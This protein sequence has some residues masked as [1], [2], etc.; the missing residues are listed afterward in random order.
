VA[1]SATTRPKVTEAMPG[2][3]GVDLYLTVD[4]AANT[5]EPSYRIISSGGVG[6]PIKDVGGPTSIPSSWFGGTTGFGVGIIS[7]SS[8]PGPEFP[9]TWEFIE[10]L[11]EGGGGGDTTAPVITKEPT[12]LLLENTVLSTSSTLPVRLNWAA[13]DD[14]GTI[15]AYELQQSTNGG[16][17]TNVALPS[18]TAT[19]INR[20]LEAGK[21]YRFQVRAQDAAGNWSG[22]K[23]GPLFEVEV[24]QESDVAVSYSGTWN[25]ETLSSAS[26][27]SLKHASASGALAKLTFGDVLNFGWV[28]HKGAN[29]GQAE[30]WVDGAKQKSI[31]LYNSS[32]QARRVVF[33][34][35]GLDPSVVHTLEV[36]VLGAKSAASSGTRVD[37]DAFVILSSV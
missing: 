14:S 27:G 3:E 30:A 21:S 4:P 35:K 7:T 29:R 8:G 25:T 32:T 18:A 5:V 31:D 9:A 19:Q 33:A 13:T 15:A 28:A 24:V 10:V 26:G 37:V 1:A 6:G 11:P 36:K 16:A 2:P 12:Q 22:W 20:T 34:H 17:F 23:Q